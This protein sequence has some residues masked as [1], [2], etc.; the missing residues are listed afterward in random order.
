VSFL[1]EDFF[2]GTDWRAVERCV[3][4]CMSHCGWHSVRVVGNTGDGGGDVIG[5]RK[6]GTKESVYVVQVKALMGGDYVGKDAI[7]EAIDA[8]TIY[9]GDIAVVAISPKKHTREETS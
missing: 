2:K 4:R 9:G 8:L 1:N 7:Q 5:V 3:A 6:T